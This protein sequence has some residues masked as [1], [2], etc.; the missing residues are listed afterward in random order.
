MVAVGVASFQRVSVVLPSFPSLK[1]RLH[2]PLGVSSANPL[3]AV[4][5]AG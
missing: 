5:A 4:W 3:E 1:V 2:Y